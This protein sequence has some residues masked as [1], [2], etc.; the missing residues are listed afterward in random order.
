[1]LQQNPKLFSGCHEKQQKVGGAASSWPWERAIGQ[2][3]ANYRAKQNADLR[4]YVC[5]HTHHGFTSGQ[6]PCVHDS[7]PRD[8]K[9]Q[10]CSRICGAAA[11][12]DCRGLQPLFR[13][14]MCVL[15]VRLLGG[16]SGPAGP[17]TVLEK[18]AWIKVRF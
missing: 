7:G 1:M 15:L 4:M 12:R 18:S 3:V 8:G 10:S 9:G 14:V 5:K 11:C 6:G 17:A 2:F 13:N 16:L